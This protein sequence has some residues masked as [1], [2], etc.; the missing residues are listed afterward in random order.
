M[1]K[2]TYVFFGSV[3]EAP[4]TGTNIPTPHPTNPNLGWVS[5]GQA[6]AIL[7]RSDKE[8]TLGLDSVLK[9]Q[10]LPTI[11]QGLKTEPRAT[12]TG[13]PF[14]QIALWPQ[15]PYFPFRV[16]DHPLNTTLLRIYIKVHIDVDWPIGDADATI[17][18]YIFV[19]LQSGKL[20]ATVDGAW[21]IVNGAWPITGT[22]A[23]KLG[24]F[25]K[26][27]IPTVQAGLDTALALAGKSTFSDVYLIPGDG[28]TAQFVAGDATRSTAL[29]L[30][31]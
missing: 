26:S 25:A 15:V 12:L 27:E 14:A 3:F 30:V 29:G 18:F 4:F 24:D 19:R 22:L 10:F 21:V 8:F 13:G 11:Q 20:K 2:S 9:T 16:A 5:F 7:H 31:P 28:S 23:D 1:L 17:S 6:E